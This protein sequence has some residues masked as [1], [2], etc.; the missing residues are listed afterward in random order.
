MNQKIIQRPNMQ[1]VIT[2][3]SALVPR[4]STRVSLE[5]IDGIGYN[6]L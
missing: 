5:I 6:A 1:T 3:T 2:L 4:I